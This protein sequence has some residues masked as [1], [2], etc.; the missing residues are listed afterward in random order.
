MID[1][2]GFHTDRDL[3]AELAELQRHIN[4]LVGR[5]ETGCFFHYE[6]R[7]NTQSRLDNLR[8]QADVIAREAA[9]EDAS[10]DRLAAAVRTV[11]DPDLGFIA[12]VV[13]GP[14]ALPMEAL[15]EVRL[16]ERTGSY[17]VG[18]SIRRNVPADKVSETE[19]ELLTVDAKRHAR[20]W[21][22]TIRDYRTQVTAY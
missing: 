14:D 15:H 8:Y 7:W 19:R 3:N 11:G 17:T 9:I 18:G 4:G 12:Y 16:I 21:G 6:D 13:F 22:R 5:L 20:L 10:I 2:L 1:T